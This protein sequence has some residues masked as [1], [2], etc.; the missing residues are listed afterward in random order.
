MSDKF[1]FTLCP[2]CGEN[3]FTTVQDK[4]HL[5][6]SRECFAC[7]YTR[8]MM[9]RASTR[10]SASKYTATPVADFFECNQSGFR[11]AFSLEELEGELEDANS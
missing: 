4:I 7:G 5:D 2:C 8:E 1:E 11:F 6:F 3:R 10:N 9:P